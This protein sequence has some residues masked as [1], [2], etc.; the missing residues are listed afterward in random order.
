MDGSGFQGTREEGL[1]R[2][3]RSVVFFSVTS[4]EAKTIADAVVKGKE[5]LLVRNE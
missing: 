3:G 1:K 2:D 4:S 5:D